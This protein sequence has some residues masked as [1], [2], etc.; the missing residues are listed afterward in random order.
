MCVSEGVHQVNESFQ[1]VVLLLLNLIYDRAL[2]SQVS[3]W[4]LFLYGYGWAGVFFFFFFYGIPT[5]FKTHPFTEETKAQFHQ[6]QSEMHMPTQNG[7]EQLSTTLLLPCNVESQTVL[8]E[9]SSSI[10]CS[11]EQIVRLPD[12]QEDSGLGSGQFILP[13]RTVFFYSHEER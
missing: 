13:C 1:E 3:L 9:C 12:K 8:R 4:S 7:L 6:F 2:R 10:N 11:T 5:I